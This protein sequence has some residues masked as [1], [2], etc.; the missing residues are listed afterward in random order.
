[1]TST[2]LSKLSLCSGAAAAAAAAA[3]VAGLAP[4]MEALVGLDAPGVAEA[5]AWSSLK[6]FASGTDE[7][8]RSR[9]AP[10][11][12]DDCASLVGV[13]G[14]FGLLAG[15]DDA[16]VASALGMMMTLL[17]MGVGDGL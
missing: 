17:P 7:L 6:R 8:E 4:L 13:W 11:A 12:C 9:V 5:S 1:M 15:G 10:A 3:V 14:A 16:M 2:K